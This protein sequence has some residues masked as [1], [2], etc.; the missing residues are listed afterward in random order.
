MFVRTGTL[1][2]PIPSILLWNINLLY[3]WHRSI[4][5]K[6]Y[7]LFSGRLYWKYQVYVGKAFNLDCLECGELRTPIFESL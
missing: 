2:E 1:R 3:G 6:K 4:K 7:S 5:P